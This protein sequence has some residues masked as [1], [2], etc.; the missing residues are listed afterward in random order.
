MGFTII[1]TCDG[2]HVEVE[3]PS[4][5]WGDLLRFCKES[6]D[7]GAKAL[8]ASD[9]TIEFESPIVTRCPAC[10][11]ATPLAPGRVRV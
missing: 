2:C 4:S 7:R 8:S 5:T 3:V 1:Q 9:G 11:A 10:S 6:F